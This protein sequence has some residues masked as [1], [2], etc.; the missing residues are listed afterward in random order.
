MTTDTNDP[1]VRHR[2]TNDLLA[3]LV[4][5]TNVGLVAAGVLGL[6]DST[7]TLMMVFG[8]LGAFGVVL[9]W[10]FGGK[11]FSAGSSLAGE[12]ADAATDGGEPGPGGEQDGSQ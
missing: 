9:Y 8:Q 7:I 4:V 1:T 5:A 2:F 6:L 10:A 11:A 12:A 3:A